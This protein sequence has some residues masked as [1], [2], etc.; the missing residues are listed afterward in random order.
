MK[1][2]GCCFSQIC[3]IFLLE[4]R[5]SRRSLFQGAV[6]E[7]NLEGLSKTTT[8]YYNQTSWWRNESNI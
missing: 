1:H 6:P 2:G 4:D 5:V 8:P 3:E 7:I